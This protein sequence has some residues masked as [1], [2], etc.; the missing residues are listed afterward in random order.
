MSDLTEV[1]VNFVF[2]EG[3]DGVWKSVFL[4]WGGDGGLVAL[5]GGVSNDGVYRGKLL[6][7]W[8][9]RVKGDLDAD[10]ETDDT[11]DM[12]PLFPDLCI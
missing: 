1:E 8:V 12:L 10:E 3:P 7:F 6:T 11:D 5:V 4:I 9:T 2:L